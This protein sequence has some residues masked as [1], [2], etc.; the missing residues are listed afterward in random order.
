[1]LN[2]LI[3]DIEKQRN[4]LL[5][6][7]DELIFRTPSKFWQEDKAF[8]LF[9]QQSYFRRFWQ[10][11]GTH[12]AFNTLIIGA[13]LLNCAQLAAAQYLPNG[14]RSSNQDFLDA[15]EP[16]FLLI[17]VIECVVQILANGFVLHKGSYLRS[18]WNIMDFT[19]VCTGLLEMYGEALFALLNMDSSILSKMKL[20][21]MGRV[22]RPLKLISN[23]PSLQVVMS[24]IL[25]AIPPIG[26]IMI[27]LI[28]FI[29]F[30]AIIG[31][32]FYVGAF[33]S[34]CY[35]L[36]GDVAV[37]GV[38]KMN[39]TWPNVTRGDRQSIRSSRYILCFV[40]DYLSGKKPNGKLS[41]RLFARPRHTVVMIQSD[42]TM[43]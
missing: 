39:L 40:N 33:H 43:E 2:R 24:A 5:H 34:A 16:W 41:L 6:D 20:L 17:F 15:T 19:V 27:L 1:M 4:C 7:K 10:F 28:F 14:D 30:F 23:S 18:G 37:D 21:K 9:S 29:V 12:F 35:D 38:C 11:I 25:K 13:I 36:A 8:F 26:N 31:L 22:F 32:D 3:I 42:Q